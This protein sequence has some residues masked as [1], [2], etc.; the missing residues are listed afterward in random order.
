M[1]PGTP[2]LLIE[3]D[4]VDVMTV[5]RALRELKMTNPLRVASN[6]EEGLA[7]L[8]S[9]NQCAPGLILLDLNMPRMNGLEFLQVVKADDQLR[10]LPVVVLTT[11]AQANDRLE[12]FN[13][14]IAGYII[15]PVDFTN[16][17]EVMRSIQDYWSHCEAAP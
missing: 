8:R 14:G 16:F 17:V 4:L 5:K 2:I 13:L 7:S 11:S 15:K 3:D 1:K 12:S 6:G 10:R 9:E